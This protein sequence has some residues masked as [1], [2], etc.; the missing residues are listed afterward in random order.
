MSD[1]TL[2]ATLVMQTRYKKKIYYPFP[3]VFQ[4]KTG[5][6][7]LDSLQLSLFLYDYVHANISS[8]KTESLGLSACCNN[9]INDDGNQV[10]SYWMS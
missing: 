2:F 6:K 4:E 7:Y 9:T 1:Q 10:M 5:Y 3:C 8:E